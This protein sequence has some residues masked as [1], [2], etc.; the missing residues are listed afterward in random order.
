MIS[1]KRVFREKGGADTY[2]KAFLQSRLDCPVYS[3][4]GTCIRSDA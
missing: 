2:E 3:E 1:K 4:C